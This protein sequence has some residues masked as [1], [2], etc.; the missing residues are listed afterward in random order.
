MTYI[1]EYYQY[2]IKNPDKAFKRLKKNYSKGIKAIQKEF[3]LL[4]L[5]QFNFR[6]YGTYGCQL[7]TGTDEESGN[8]LKI[9]SP[10]LELDGYDRLEISMRNTEIS[11]STKLILKRRILVYFL[12]NTDQSVCTESSQTK[13]KPLKRCTAFIVRFVNGTYNGNNHQNRSCPLPH[14]DRFTVENQSGQCRN[15]H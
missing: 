6:I 12:Q 11:E 14:R 7:T 5:S 4:P 1:E 15:Y 10:E 2:L 9:I 8:I 13:Q 3:N